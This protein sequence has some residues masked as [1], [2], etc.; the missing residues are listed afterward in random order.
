[1]RSDASRSDNQPV[2]NETSENS[3]VPI[4]PT[5]SGLTDPAALARRL[6][7]AEGAGEDELIHRY[8]RGV[9]I[10]IGRIVRDPLT[11]ADLCQEA[12]RL[13]LEKLRRG[14]LREPGKLSG[15]ICGVARNLAIEH[16]RRARPVQPLEAALHAPDPNPSPLAR[17]VEKEQV[18][19]VRR[20]LSEM[21]TARDREILYRFYL[22]EEDK[23]DICSQLGL[24]SLHFNR[25]LHRA[26]QRFKELY[27]QGM[28]KKSCPDAG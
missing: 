18:E 21:T 15:F 13:V 8:S 12:L 28:T 4:S 25:V 3:G 14:C 26:R 24:S 19:A 16:L 17:L 10:I 5:Q 9:A 7:Q 2:I 22:L 20:V 27:R 11:T 23:E 6:Q 1:M